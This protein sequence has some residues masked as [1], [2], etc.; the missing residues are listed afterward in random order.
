MDV[1]ESLILALLLEVIGEKWKDDSLWLS[2]NYDLA[3][4]RVARPGAVRN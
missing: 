4:L 2:Y 1:L 3:T